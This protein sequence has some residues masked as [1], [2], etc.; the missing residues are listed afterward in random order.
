MS[1]WKSAIRLIA[2]TACVGMLT[3]MPSFADSQVRIV[4][5][6]DVQG[7]VQIDRNTGQGYEKAFLNLPI[8][9]GVKLQTKSDGRAQVEFEDG[10]VMRITPGTVVEFPELMMRDSGAKISTVHVQEGKAYVNFLGAK[11]A[12]DDVL[13]L[14]F[15][16]EKI[17]LTQPAHLRLEMGDAQARLAVFGGD[18]AVEGSFGSVA[19][20]KNH[21]LTVDLADQSRYTSARWVDDDPYDAWDKQQ[22]QYQQRY[23]NNAPYTGSSPYS[24][25]TSD[26]NYYGSFSNVPGYGTMWQ[27]YL[28][29]A[30]WDPFMNGAWAYYPGSGYGWVSGYPWGWTPYYSGAW[31]FVPGY[32]WMWEPG[33]TWAGLGAFPIIVNPPT[34]FIV[35]R[36]PN[37]PGQRILPASRGASPIP[38]GDSAGKLTIVNNSAGLGI[39]R[40]GV[41]NLSVLSQTVQLHGFVA[42]RVLDTSA[43]RPSWWSGYSGNSGSLASTPHSGVPAASQSSGGM[44]T[45]THSSGGSHASG[46][47]HR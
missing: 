13:T 26:L 16:H 9:Q 7:D 23:A 3:A 38:A 15:G 8:T 10:S 21:T 44:A 19:V 11:G 41:K 5:L 30:G 4:R 14:V 6:S 20:A 36:P 32:G 46:G 28:A 35:P 33:G 18:I 42:T 31:M 47:G 29:G 24:Y 43:V 27:P 45:T 34:N 25:G 40:G 37:I 39:P 1:R 22:D 2:M 12:K 17:T